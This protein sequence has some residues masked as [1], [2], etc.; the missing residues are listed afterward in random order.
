MQTGACGKVGFELTTNGI[1]FKFYVFAN[2]ARHPYD[3]F[4]IDMYKYAISK[5]CKTKQTICNWVYV[6]SDAYFAYIP[7]C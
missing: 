4:M 3:D 2:L 7:L 5:I 1:Q 6:D